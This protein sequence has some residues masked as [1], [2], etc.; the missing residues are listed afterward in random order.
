MYL[1]TVLGSYYLIWAHIALCPNLLTD[2]RNKSPPD[3]FRLSRVSFDPATGMPTEP[4]TSTTAAVNIM[5]NAN[6]GNCP[7]QCFRPVNVAWGPNG[8]LFMTSDT[9]NEIWVIGGA[10]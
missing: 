7:N 10:T 8:Q 9:T 4:V 1:S 3:G 5:Y 2:G 6:N